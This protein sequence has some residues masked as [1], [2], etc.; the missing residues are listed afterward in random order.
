[1]IPDY[2]S[3]SSVEGWFDHIDYV[4]FQAVLKHQSVGR[5]G[6]LVEVGP[7][8]GKCSVAMGGWVRDGEEFRVVDLFG[9]PA[10]DP[11]NAA[12]VAWNSYQGLSRATFESN[13]K[14][15]YSKLPVILEGE[16][17][18]LL[19]TLDAATVRF[20]HIDGSHVRERVAEDLALSLT[21][22]HQ[23]GVVVVDD[24]RTEHAPGVA[25]AVWPMIASG[26][27][28]PFA[29]TPQKLYAAPRERP[30]LQAAVA[31]AALECGYSVDFHSVRGAGS[32]IP[33]LSGRPM[34]R[35]SPAAQSGSPPVRGRSLVKR[36]RK[37][38]HGIRRTKR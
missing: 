7:F 10:V 35:S 19:R 6:N 4:V 15:F 2:E 32:L 5:P 25:A 8:Q 3:L 23:D 16:S 38:F 18:L 30:D 27:F 14:Q 28:V 13:Y 26:R 36:I 11:E 37:K 20:I 1:M 21:A 33:R 12:E 17:A 31:D 29:L 22:L 24:Y 9:Q 34:R